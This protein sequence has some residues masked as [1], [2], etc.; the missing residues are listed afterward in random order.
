[1]DRMALKAI[2][3]LREKTLQLIYPERQRRKKK[4]HKVDTWVRPPGDPVRVRWYFKTEMSER[5][6]KQAL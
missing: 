4:F 2:I 6:K 1:M 5:E 3:L